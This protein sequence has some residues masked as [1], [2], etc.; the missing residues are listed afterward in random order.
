MRVRRKGDT[1]RRKGGEGGGGEKK[2]TILA[3]R[4]SLVTAII[5]QRG[6]YWAKT[7]AVLYIA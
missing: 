3:V 6:R 1:G 4:A 7:K 5:G 2:L